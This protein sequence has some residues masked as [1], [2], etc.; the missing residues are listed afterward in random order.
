M[1]N[2]VGVPK[3]LGTPST[4]IPDPHGKRQWAKLYASSGL[5][6]LDVRNRSTFRDLEHFCFFIGYS[7]SG[8]TLIGATLNAHPEMVI[9]HERDAVSFVTHGFRRSQLFPLLIQRDRQ[10]GSMGRSWSDYQYE[11]PDQYQGRFERLRVIGDKRARSSVLQIARDPKL[12]DRLRMVVGVPIRVI[13]VTR[14]PFDNIATEARRHKMTLS[15]ATEWYEEICRAVDRVRPLLDSTELIDLQY[16]T[17]ATYPRHT[18]SGL[19]ASMGVESEP[20]YLDACAGIV[21]PSTNRS[22]DSVDWTD[23]ELRAVEQLI[24]RYEVLQSYTFHG[25]VTD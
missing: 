21:W 18:L 2:R 17:F 7:R 3:R 22:R 5:Y 13:H 9:A 15:A 6:A 19:C 12:L 8:H 1:G 24:E 16:E 25:E 23:E 11:I 10:F 4:G 14:N 20:S